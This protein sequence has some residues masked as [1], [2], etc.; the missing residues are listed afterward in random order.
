MMGTG[1]GQAVGVLVSPLLTRIYSPAAVG[2]WQRY[3][4]IFG[5]CYVV[6][7]GRYEQAILLPPEDTDALCL[8]MC[9]MLVAL[10]VSSLCALGMIGLRLWGGLSQHYFALYAW[11]LPTGAMFSGGALALSYWMLRRH[12]FGR[13]A[14]AKIS[15]GATQAGVQVGLGSMLGG[16]SAFLIA[17]DVAARVAAFAVQA[18]VLVREMRRKLCAVTWRRIRSQAARY[19]AFPRISA[20]SALINSAGFGVPMLIMAHAFGDRT[21]GFIALAD[22]TINAPS[23]LIGQ[24]VSQV[25]CSQAS[26]YLR[27]RAAILPLYARYARALSLFAAVPAALLWWSA[28]I[29]A[30][31]LLGRAWAPTATFIRI[32]LPSATLGFIIWPLIPTLNLLERQHKQLAWDV[33]RCAVTIGVTV[34]AVRWRQPTIAALAYSIAMGCMYLVHM[35]VSYHE[36]KRNQRHQPQS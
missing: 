16:L 22:R 12:H 34:L 21:F 17:G 29:L 30:P 32:T 1:F 4:A 35:I 33:T 13:A 8:V 15:Q 20:V 3:M 11:S 14:A 36:L 24:A 10:C 23:T 31:I 28:P 9:S 7:C 27:Q 2:E 19:S 25:Y 6:V 5:L 26:S 18:P